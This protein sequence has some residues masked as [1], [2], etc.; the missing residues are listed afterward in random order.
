MSLARFFPRHLV[1]EF[2]TVVF[3]CCCCCCWFCS[4]FS[5]KSSYFGLVFRIVSTA[6]TARIRQC[7]AFAFESFRK[8][9]LLLKELLPTTSLLRRP[10]L[11]LP[12]C[13]ISRIAVSLISTAISRFKFILSLPYCSRKAECCPSLHPG[14]AWIP[15]LSWNEGIRSSGHPS[16]R[17]LHLQKSW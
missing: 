15:H 9:L 4:I 7:C 16:P 6:E 8:S 1:P 3:H 13:R 11:F 17:H 10:L 14:D 2:W 5:L 12:S